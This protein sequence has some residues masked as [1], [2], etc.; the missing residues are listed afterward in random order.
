MALVYG[1]P[2]GLNNLFSIPG[3]TAW[4]MIYWPF[5]PKKRV[6]CTCSKV[7]ITKLHEAWIF[8]TPSLVYATCL[9]FTLDIIFKK[10]IV[11]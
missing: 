4:A 1:G 7:M 3:L 8:A 2:S 11:V 5:R 6:P 10:F 9:I